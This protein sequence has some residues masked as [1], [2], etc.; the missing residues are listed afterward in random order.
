M[1]IRVERATMSQVLLSF[2]RGITWGGS[3]W[4]LGR[5]PTYTPQVAIQH[6][7]LIV[8]FSLYAWSWKDSL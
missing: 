2:C 7:V 5:F 4:D 6:G 8:L 3:L 1:R